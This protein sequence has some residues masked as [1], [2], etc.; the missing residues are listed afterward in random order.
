MIG[1]IDEAI[2][3]IAM[4]DSAIDSALENEVADAAR[5]CIAHSAEN[6]VYTAY[7]PKVLYSRRGSAGGLSAEANI[8]ATA[9]GKEL[10]VRNATGLQNLYGG[11]RQ[12]ILTN[13]V[14]SG[15]YSYHMQL[16]GPRP[17]MEEAKD[18]LMNGPG[19]QALHAGLA[20]QGII[21]D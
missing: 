2:A 7:T 18:L 19:Q 4:L 9:G 15:S 14:E 20:R 11:G 1:S 5:K 21:L 3:K 6:N 13:I 12:E 10:T 8:Q 17:F 16:A